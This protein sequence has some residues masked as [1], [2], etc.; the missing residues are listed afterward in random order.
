MSKVQYFKNIFSTYYSPLCNYALK[1]TRNKDEAEDIVQN[2]F[3]YF[4]ENDSLENVENIEGYLLRSVKFKCIDYL[5]SKNSYHFRI[6]DIRDYSYN[7]SCEITDDEIEPL[8][9]YFTAK[10]PPKTKE[11]FL[12]SRKSD[13]TYKQ[14]SAELNISVK[15]VESQMSRALKH[16]RKMLKAQGFFSLLIHI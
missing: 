15:T 3:I 5:R 13:M 4:W 6:N 10:L 14:I 16:M 11:V 2:L 1:I 12:L 7:T 8:L 9:A